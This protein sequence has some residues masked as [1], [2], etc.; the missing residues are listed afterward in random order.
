MSEQVPAI[1]HEA[2]ST[3]YPY[4]DKFA[5]RSERVR[6]SR[7]ALTNAH[8]SDDFRPAII[9]AAQVEGSTRREVAKARQAGLMRHDDLERFY[10]LWIVE[11]EEQARVLEFVAQQNHWQV[12]GPDNALS[13]R[14]R[15]REYASP[16]GLYAS[17]LLSGRT[18]AFLGVGAAAEYVTRALYRGLA[19]AVAHRELKRCLF[20]MA[21][22]EASH[23][24]FFLAAARA[25][26]SPGRGQSAFI[27]EALRRGWNPVGMDRLGDAAWNSAFESLLR[28]G[29]IRE[30]LLRM[31]ETL[32]T[33]PLFSGLE[34]MTTFLSRRS[35]AK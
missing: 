26:P 15:M 1:A 18:I 27:R 9:A 7:D 13:T 24:T 2:R 10:E 14:H 33:I 32:D 4:L 16:V 3:P 29:S 21:A 8:V 25:R 22:Q 34:L 11:E 23:M 17:Q 19:R 35:P 12:S 20:R 5:A 28:I 31:D 30:E 6:W